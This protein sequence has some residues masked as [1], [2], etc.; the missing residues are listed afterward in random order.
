MSLAER[1]GGLQQ[2]LGDLLAGGLD[3]QLASVLLRESA[4]GCDVALTQDQLAEMLG[5]ARTSIQRVL[6]QLEADGLIE[7][8]YRR[9]TVVDPDGL[10]GLVGTS[11]A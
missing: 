4:D 11:P 7:L 10:A 5:S 1:M 8:G 6:K 2:R 9:I 3:A